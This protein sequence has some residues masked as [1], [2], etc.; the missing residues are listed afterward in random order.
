MKTG[1]DENLLINENKAEQITKMRSLS[2]HEFLSTHCEWTGFWYTNK[3]IYLRLS[4]KRGRSFS[5]W[6]RK[7][8]ASIRFVLNTEVIN[9]LD[10]AGLI[11]ILL[12]STLIYKDIFLSRRYFKL[13]RRFA[14]ARTT[15]NWKRTNQQRF[16]SQNNHSNESGLDSLEV[17]QID[18]LKFVFSSSCEQIDF[19][20]IRRSYFLGRCFLSLSET[21]FVDK[22]CG[23]C[24]EIKQNSIL[25]S[26]WLE[27]RSQ[28]SMIVIH[29]PREQFPSE[30]RDV[31][32]TQ[33]RRSE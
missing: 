29:Q 24:F 10:L 31:W 25:D 12:F 4:K 30:K 11:C 21:A 27:K 5:R 7:F 14:H 23:Q 3:K 20:H 6:K 22:K 19:R 26:N 18:E 33:T 8:R 32:L 1:K 13:N 2:E 28:Q 17:E 15:F 9:D 16:C